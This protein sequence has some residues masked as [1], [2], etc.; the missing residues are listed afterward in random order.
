VRCQKG[1][2]T[3]FFVASSKNSVS[4][5][6]VKRLKTIF[7]S[8]SN[9]LPKNNSLSEGVKIDRKLTPIPP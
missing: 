9:L 6:D 2:R 3:P 5:G 4:K 8:Y 7:Y 1:Y